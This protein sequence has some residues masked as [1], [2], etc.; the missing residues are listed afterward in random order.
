MIN[1]KILIIDNAS[2][3]NLSKIRIL[4]DYFI[5]NS[6]NEGLAKAY[7]AALQIALY[8]NE[9]WIL[10][11]DQDTRLN[12]NL[13]LQK[14]FSE[15]NKLSIKDRVAIISI[16]RIYAHTIKNLDNFKICKS[17]VNSGSLLNVKI[18]STFKYNED[19]FIDRIDN[20]YC[21][22]L[23]KHGF[24]ILVYSNQL[25]YH[26][27]GDNTRLYRKLFSRSILFFL[28]ILS[29]RHGIKEFRKVVRYRDFYIVYNN[30]YRY[31]TIIR[32]TIYLCSR[33]L[34]DLYH[35]KTIPSWT[36]SLY[37]QTNLIITLKLLTLGIFHGILG[38]LKE[39]NKKITKYF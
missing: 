9:D 22:R 24:Y 26:K 17:V 3:I 20:E 31:Y 13:D 7:N 11:L 18:C 38:D 12:E 2:S 6:V 14:I 37:E 16:N 23:R 1:S 34:I 29:I 21:Y 19:L 30:Y 4:C 25:I 35:I 32:N 39:D 15:Y 8:L 27:I 28:K 10:L 5:R 33:R 36:L